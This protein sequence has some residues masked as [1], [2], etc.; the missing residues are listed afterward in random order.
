MTNHSRYTIDLHWLFTIGMWVKGIDGVVE[1]LGGC[2]LLLLKPAALSRLVIVLT[3]HELVEDPQDRVATALR[4]LVA[5][6][7]ISTQLFGSAYLI[8][9]GFVKLLIVVG[10]LSGR[11]WAYPIAIG[12]LSLF[13]VYQCYRLSYSYNLGLLVLTMFDIVILGLTW[14]EYTSNKHALDLRG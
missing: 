6:L 2:L 3:Q 4:A 7:S 11:R 14:R 5:R 10:V 9:H 8:A 1:I 12:F 13:I